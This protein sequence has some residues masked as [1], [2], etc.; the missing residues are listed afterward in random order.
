MSGN[1]W[2]WTC[3]NWRE[4]FDGSEQQCSDDTTNTQFRVLRGG[5][6]FSYPGRARAAAL[7]FFVLFVVLLG[8]NTLNT[9]LIAFDFVH[10]NYYRLFYLEAKWTMRT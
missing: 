5:S 3:S 4:R 7:E 2:E 10:A 8:I 6:W 9:S 1:V